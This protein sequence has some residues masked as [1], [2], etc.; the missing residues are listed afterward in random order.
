MAMGTKLLK[1]SEAKSK[2]MILLTDGRNTAGKIPLQVAEKLLEQYNIKLYTIGVGR[3]MHW[4]P[5]RW[6]SSR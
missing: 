6:N 3:S 5:P 4:S 2:V 1:D